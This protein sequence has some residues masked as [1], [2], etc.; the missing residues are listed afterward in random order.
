MIRTRTTRLIAL[1]FTSAI[2]AGC[3]TADDPARWTWQQW[4]RALLDGTAPVELPPIPPD[5]W[6][7]RGE[8][9]WFRDSA[10][11]ADYDG[12]GAIDYVRIQD[13]PGSYDHRVWVDLDG[14][15]WFDARR[16]ADAANDVRHR[17][18]AFT[19]KPE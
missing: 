12:D 13:P 8:H 17:V 3:A 11:V 6:E 2:A 9:G 7:R 5:G 4:S 14:D 10:Q 15:G 18:P 1:T 16:G 19:P